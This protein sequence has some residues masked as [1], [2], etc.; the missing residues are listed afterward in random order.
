MLLVLVLL[1]FSIGEMEVA[2]VGAA[3]RGVEDMGAANLLKSLLRLAGRRDKG[4]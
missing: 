3:D 2:D 1:L 4:K